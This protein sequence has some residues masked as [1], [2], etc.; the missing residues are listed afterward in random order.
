MISK[1]NHNQMVIILM[2]IMKSD[3]GSSNK[4]M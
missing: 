1:N 4:I 2:N 3:V